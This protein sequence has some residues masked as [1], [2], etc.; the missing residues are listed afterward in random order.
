MGE[1]TGD[2][3][4]SGGTEWSVRAMKLPV[5]K[6]GGAAAVQPGRADAASPKLVAQRIVGD[7]FQ[8]MPE[9]IRR[10]EAGG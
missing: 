9:L 4:L 1:Q 7:K 3:D 6:S 10:L 5:S 2:S 8:V